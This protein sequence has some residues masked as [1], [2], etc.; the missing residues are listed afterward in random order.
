MLCPA[1]NKVNPDGAR[2]CAFC[3]KPLDAPLAEPP[4]SEPPSSTVFAFDPATPQVAAP[5]TPATEKP[6][7]PRPPSEKPP[8]AYAGIDRRYELVELLGKGGM[9]A[10]FRAHDTRLG[11]D[12]AIK[13]IRAEQA[14]GAGF[15]RFERE[16]QS[17]AILQ[18]PNIVTLFDTAR[19][20]EGP[21]LVM[22]YVQGESLHNRLARLGAMEDAAAFAVFEGLCKGVSHAHAKGLIHRDIKPSNVILD[23]AGTAKLLDF[24]LARPIE[25]SELSQTGAFIGT[26]DYAAPEQKTDAKSVDHRC[27]QYSLGATFYEMLTGLRPAPLALLKLSEKWRPLIGRACDPDPAARFAS[28]EEFLAAARSALDQSAERKR[29][30]GRA[31]DLNCPQCRVPNTLEADTCRACSA[32]LREVCVACEKPRRVGLIHCNLCGADHM[33]AKIAVAQREAAKRAMAERRIKDAIEELSELNALMRAH[34]A[35]IGPLSALQA[36]SEKETARLK[37]NREKA[38]Q[39]AAQARVRVTEGRMKGA[40][41]KMSAAA[42]LDCAFD[43]EL[44]MLREGGA[45]APNTEEQA[46]HDAKRAYDALTGSVRTRVWSDRSDEAPL[47]AVAPL[48]QKPTTRVEKDP[49]LPVAPLGQKSPTTK[50][51]N[52]MPADAIKIR[53][54]ACGVVIVTRQATA[55]KLQAC[56]KCKAAP[57]S[58]SPTG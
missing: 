11:R 37:A 40:I 52:N 12:V 28:V 20:G 19:D 8:L 6:A 24:G 5:Q 38:A 50:T 57:F 15:Q 44:A 39:L 9:G 2:F 32:S 42:A 13:R 55:E 22:E 21:F 16:A 53:C 54:A 34:G 33:A 18:H 14:N 25:S 10:V 29:T 58:Y 45:P 36:W 1:C 4:S 27:D 43:Q 35:E 23:R 31:D 17:V 46:P 49:P 56:P 51:G 26:L 41:E 48:G 7:T 3:G 47:P 30:V